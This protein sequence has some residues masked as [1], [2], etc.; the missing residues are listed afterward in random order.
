MAEVIQSFN[1]LTWPGAIGLAAVSFSIAW[2]VG[3]YVKAVF[4]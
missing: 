4:G 3:A 1:G 2:A